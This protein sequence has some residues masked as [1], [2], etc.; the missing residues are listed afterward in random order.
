MIEI[1]HRPV[2]VFHGGSLEFPGKADIL[3][4]SDE[5]KTEVLPVFNP[6]PDLLAD[7]LHDGK[8]RFRLLQQFLGGTAHAVIQLNV[9]VWHPHLQ[10]QLNLHDPADVVIVVVAI[11]ALRVDERGTEQPLALQAKDG[12]PGEAAAPAD[13][14]D[15]KQ[16]FHFDCLT[17][18]DL[19]MGGHVTV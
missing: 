4:K 17:G 8:P 12:G 5:F 16:I 7:P 19:S 10:E 6:Q 15:C 11:A 14:V 18:V 1:V 2:A 9:I 13:L 3:G